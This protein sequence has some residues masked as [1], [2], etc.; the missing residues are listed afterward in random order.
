MRNRLKLLLGAAVAIG[1]AAGSIVLVT[2]Q[3]ADAADH[4]DPPGAAASGATD[5]PA[6]DIDDVYA[7]H[8]GSNLNI[9]TTFSGPTAPSATAGTRGIYSRNSQFLIHISENATP[10]VDTH[11]IKVRFG[12]ATGRWGVQLSGIPGR[13]EPL[14]GPVESLLQSRDVKAFVGLRDDPFFFD[15]EGFRATLSTGALAFMTTRDFFAGKNTTAIALQFPT[16]A[17]TTSGN[18]RVWVSSGTVAP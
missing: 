1:A 3:P 13:T 15:L 5:Q 9:V 12:Q 6:A 16:T 17:A 11:T 18:I 14:V 2:T 8:E 4:N 7:W 10:T